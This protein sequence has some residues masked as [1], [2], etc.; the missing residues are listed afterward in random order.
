MHDDRNRNT[1]EATK[2]KFFI[3][4]ALVVSIP[5]FPISI[6]FLPFAIGAYVAFVLRNFRGNPSHLAGNFAI[7]ILLSACLPFLV[8][9]ATAWIPALEMGPANFLKSLLGW[10]LFGDCLEA[11]LSSLP[12]EAQNWFAIT[13]VGGIFAM[14][15]IYLLIPEAAGLTKGMPYRMRPSRAENHHIVRFVKG[16][17]GTA[18]FLAAAALQLFSLSIHYGLIDCDQSRAH[19]SIYT[20]RSF[21]LE[22]KSN[23]NTWQ[24]P[25][26][27]VNAVL[28]GVV[29]VLAG[30]VDE[31]RRR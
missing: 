18:F 23:P 21:L 2:L 22:L 16:R 17:T 6:A 1:L 30:V 14:P 7:P 15:A 9:S 4:L 5:I 8:S 13:L 11:Q 29:M 10:S 25:Y 28:F 27:I 26:L 12:R 20:A 24:L 31:V 3:V 19:E